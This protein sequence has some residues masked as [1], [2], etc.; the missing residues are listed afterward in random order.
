MENFV[1]L[2]RLVG[3]RCMREM[4][5][6]VILQ[7]GFCGIW[8]KSKAN[9]PIVFLFLSIFVATNF[10]LISSTFVQFRIV[11]QSGETNIVC[12]R[13]AYLFVSLKFGATVV[14]NCKFD[15]F[16]T[17]KC[18]NQIYSSISL[19]TRSPVSARRWVMMCTAAT[20]NW[21]SSVIQRHSHVLLDGVTCD[22]VK[23]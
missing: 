5:H 12:K 20:V 21:V 16:A 19:G 4:G 3:R 8:W 23:L 11:R 22:P 7:R 6:C 13:S 18:D 10:V 1:Q 17:W 15:N 2:V 9:I 14:S